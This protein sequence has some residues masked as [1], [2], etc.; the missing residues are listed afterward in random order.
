VSFSL[1]P[2]AY[3][4]GWLVAAPIGPVNLEI[5]RRSLTRRLLCGL[6][7]GLG[8]TCVDASYLIVFTTGFGHVLTTY[9]SLSR[10]LYLIGG[11][12]LTWIG[13]GAL[14]EALRYLQRGMGEV[15]R[16]E[17]TEM[18]R[19]ARFAESLPGH[20]LLGVAMTAAN[21]MTLAFWSSLALNFAELPMSQRLLASG[22]VWLGAFS[23]VLTLMALLAFARRW[24]G[25]RLYALVTS[26]G[27]L[28]LLF[29]GLRFLWRGL[30]AG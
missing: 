17:R 28:C 3:A 6:L 8:A 23:W 19:W 24:V 10:G 26:A 1:L 9:P 30:M 2:Q 14:R 29:F 20:F 15:Q 27:G 22:F 11:A 18:T 12:L 16:I 21:P 13:I 7:V 5:I 4:T 25:A